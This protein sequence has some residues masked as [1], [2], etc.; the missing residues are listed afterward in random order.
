MDEIY[1]KRLADESVM[2][3]NY[4]LGCDPPKEIVGRYVAANIALFGKQIVGA[5]DSELNFVL[6]HPSMLPFIEAAAGIIKPD[7]ILRRKIFVM[8][9]ILETTPKYA[10]FFL[11]IPDSIFKILC[12]LAWN[13]LRG[14][15][16][17]AV[18]IPIFVIIGK[19]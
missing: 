14:V 13:G 7:S 2:I 19:R 6:R 5:Q 15:I 12:Y 10:N 18:G 1:K 3:T 17:L 8:S 9:A 11:D 16:K 4:L